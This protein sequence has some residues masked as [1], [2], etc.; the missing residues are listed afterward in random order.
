M[1]DIHDSRQLP[2][3]LIP[4]LP[5][6][7]HRS[8]GM[9]ADRRE[10]M[11]ERFPAAA[12]SNLHGSM[13][14]RVLNHTEWLYAMAPDGRPDATV[15][16]AALIAQLGAVWNGIEAEPPVRRLVLR[17]LASRALGHDIT[18]TL[19]DLNAWG[20]AHFVAG[21]RGVIGDGD[22]SVPLPSATFGRTP[23]IDALLSEVAGRHA[24]SATVALA[25]IARAKRS[26]GVLPNAYFLWLEHVDRT[27]WLLL[28]GYGSRSP[29]IE[30]FGAITHHAA[31][32]ALGM[33]R[34]ALM[35]DKE[36]EFIL[37]LPSLAIHS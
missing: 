20:I 12:F 14:P 34:T 30:V 19:E 6:Q 25:I 3:S 26:G 4:T 1:R 10:A 31:E 21:G 16:K 17:L 33:P 15:I 29:A 27:L 24:W 37:G 23:E 32:Q 36:V 2:S 28:S 18:A 9:D 11:A 13:V 35:M 5:G 7:H 8:P 22:Y